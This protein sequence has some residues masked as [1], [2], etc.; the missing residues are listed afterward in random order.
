MEYLD[1]TNV[2]ELE[3]SLIW[4]YANPHVIHWK[5]QHNMAH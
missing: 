1:S 5:R 3:T 2:F 4:L